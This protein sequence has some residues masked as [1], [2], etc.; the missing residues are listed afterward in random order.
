MKTHTNAWWLCASVNHRI[1]AKSKGQKCNY[2]NQLMVRINE[3]ELESGHRYTR[4]TQLETWTTEW[5]VRTIYG[6]ILCV[7]VGGGKST[8]PPHHQKR[9]KKQNKKV[10][11]A[12][13]GSVP[14]KSQYSRGR[15]G[16]ISVDWKDQPVLQWVPR[17]G[18]AINTL[19]Y[20]CAC[21]HA[22][23]HMFMWYSKYFFLFL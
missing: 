1:R 13:C 21:T 6:E 17:T 22:H 16:Q 5:T 3:V 23:R 2:S 18:R 10:K 9:Q 19:Q 12:M 8:L 20:K 14:L 11:Q 7:C 15:N 4:T